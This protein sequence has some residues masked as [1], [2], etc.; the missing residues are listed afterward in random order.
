MS[1]EYTT[2]FVSMWLSF[3]RLTLEVTIEHAEHLVGFD[4]VDHLPRA[5][6]IS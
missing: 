4:L 6:D 5:L 2:C 1:N 3:V